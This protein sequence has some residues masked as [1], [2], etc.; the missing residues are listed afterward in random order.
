[1]PLLTFTSP[2]GFDHVEHTEPSDLYLAMLADGL[3]E[4][5]DWDEVRIAS[6]LA[7]IARRTGGRGV[8]GSSLPH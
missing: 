8:V 1:M 4:S 5:R 6:Y 3:R 2:H 7:G